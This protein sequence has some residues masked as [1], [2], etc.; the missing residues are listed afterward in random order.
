MLPPPAVHG[1][2]SSHSLFEVRSSIITILVH[3]AATFLSL[4][5][6][7]SFA[8]SA[9]LM[10]AL[11]EDMERNLPDWMIFPQEEDATQTFS[12]SL[13]SWS[14]AREV[15]EASV[16]LVRSALLLSLREVGCSTI[17]VISSK[18]AFPV[19][20]WSEEM[21]RD[22]AETY[23][24]AC[25]ADLVRHPH[26]RLREDL[27]DALP[28]SPSQLVC[29]FSMPDACRVHGHALGRK[30]KGSFRACMPSVEELRTRQLT[31]V[32]GGSLSSCIAR[33]VRKRMAG[34]AEDKKSRSD[35]CGARASCCGPPSPPRDLFMADGLA[36]QL[37]AGGGSWLAL[38]PPHR[39]S[40]HAV[41][42]SSGPMVLRSGQANE[43]FL[44]YKHKQLASPSPTELRVGQEPSL[45]VLLRGLVAVIRWQE[46]PHAQEESIAEL[47]H[48]LLHDLGESISNVRAVLQQISSRQGGNLLVAEP[49]AALAW[50]M[51]ACAIVCDHFPM[52][53]GRRKEI[54]E[55]VMGKMKEALEATMAVREEETRFGPSNVAKEELSSSC[56]A[57]F[58]RPCGNKQ[59]HQ[60]RGYATGGSSGSTARLALQLASQLIIAALGDKEKNL[61]PIGQEVFIA[62]GALHAIVKAMLEAANGQMPPSHVIDVAASLHAAC[63][64]TDMDGVRVII[65][66]A[67]QEHKNPTETQLKTFVGE[68]LSDVCLRDVRRFKR[69]LK[70]FC[71]GKKKGM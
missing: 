69:V 61:P 6:E 47:L 71:G 36:M 63:V 11:A 27:A 70:A 35:A 31:S 66:S 4:K 32:C 49:L 56:S 53:L 55:A 34:L 60:Q 21:E 57:T 64:R 43:A 33:K 10:K 67:A 2:S 3:S 62:G 44:M 1:I 42:Q 51:R 9:E 45:V 16:P 14:S 18:I 22:G 5:N 39:L 59:H 23:G 24:G 65:E 12:Q 7:E 15:S 46:D 52:V 40:D 28:T 54:E 41:A 68:L 25:E 30:Q 17:S 26:L 8:I 19:D 37:S 58:S 20:C 50:S 29:K 13:S 48:P 38:T